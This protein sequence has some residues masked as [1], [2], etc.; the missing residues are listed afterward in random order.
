MKAPAC[1]A[2]KHQRRK[3]TEDCFLAPFFPPEK[4]NDFDA[5]HKLF[6]VRNIVSH[7]QKLT[8]AQ[9]PDAITSMVYEANARVIYPVTG[10]AGIVSMLQQRLGTVYA[11]VL[12]ARNELACHRALEEQ[13]LR[14]QNMV[15]NA[16]LVDFF[17][18]NNNAN[19]LFQPPNQEFNFL[20]QNLENPQQL[21][22]SSFAQETTLFGRD[23]QGTS[24][25]SSLP[26]Q[27]PLQMNQETGF[28]QGSY[29]PVGGS[30]NNLSIG[31][32]KNVF[33]GSDVRPNRGKLVVNPQWGKSPPSSSKAYWNQQQFGVSG[34]DFD[35]LD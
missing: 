4:A 26:V 9:R 10:C 22:E 19:L 15:D 30:M 33:G 7:L 6:G 32:S 16:G 29:P 24:L 17:Q 1:A 31:A 35:D 34:D 8:P 13:Q 3:C 2:C 11:Q 12:A 25:T 21:Q 20:P 27:R 18:S 28:L 14:Q 5:V 23:R